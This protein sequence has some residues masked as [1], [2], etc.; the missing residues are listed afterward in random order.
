MMSFVARKSA[1]LYAVIIV[2]LYLGC[3]IHVTCKRFAA[4]LA[5]EMHSSS[6]RSQAY[7]AGACCV[8]NS[9]GDAERYT[10]VC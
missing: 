2:L 7:V 3:P 1:T 6:S 10:T 8:A 5:R 9:S 4:S